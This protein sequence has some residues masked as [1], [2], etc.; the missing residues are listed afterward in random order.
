MTF[1]QLVLRL[2]FLRDQHL[3]KQQMGLRVVMWR[4]GQI[5]LHVRSLREFALF[6]HHGRV[7]HLIPGPRR[8]GIRLSSGRGDLRCLEQQHQSILVCDF[9]GEAAPWENKVRLKRLAVDLEGN[10]A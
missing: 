3:R 2:A 4:W 8:A 6:I 5:V 10:D 9:N 1:V 7:V